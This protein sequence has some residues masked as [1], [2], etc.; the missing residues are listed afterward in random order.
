MQIPLTTAMRAL[1][2]AQP[3]SAGDLVFPS[4]RTAMQLRGWTGLVAAA[5][6][7][8]GAHRS[9]FTT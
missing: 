9:S 6:S 5:A 1:L 7:A 3:K 2:M 4:S 8:S